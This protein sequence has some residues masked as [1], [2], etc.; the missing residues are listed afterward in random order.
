[1]ELLA[2]KNYIG[3][4]DSLI[5]LNSGLDKSDSAKSIDGYNGKLKL[6]GSSNLPQSKSAYVNFMYYP[7]TK[8]LGIIEISN[9]FCQCYVRLWL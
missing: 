4:Y 7:N 8:K 9:Y 2:G 1:M 6:I 5:F 3:Q